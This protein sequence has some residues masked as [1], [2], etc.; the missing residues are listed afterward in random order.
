MNLNTALQIVSA[1]VLANRKLNGRTSQYTTP[2]LWGTA[3]CGKTTG[4]E[5]VADGLGIDCR[6]VILAQYDAGELGGF[7]VLQ[8]GEMHRARPAF[9][10]TEG[11]GILFLDELPQAPVANQNI[12]AQLVNERRIGEHKLGDGW[13]IVC[14]G[15]DLKHRAGT[16]AMPSHLKDRLLHLEVEP[17]LDDTLEY[18]NAKGVDPIVCGFLRFS[19]DQLSV[20]DKDAKAC[21][22][23][24]SW[25]KISNILSWGLPRAAESQAFAGQVG[26][27]AGAK[28]EA[29]LQMYR[30]LPNP[31]QPLTDPMNAPV[32]EKA[33][34]LYALLAGI[35]ARVNDKNAD[36][37]LRYVDR[38]PQGEFG[39]FAVKSAKQRYPEIN[40][41]PAFKAWAVKNHTLLL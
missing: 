18:F 40:K 17:S 39:A 20:F 26:A 21:P 14:A 1:S 4:V 36:N 41:A 9:L 38:I 33:S 35:S 27:G 24:R 25:E 7:P 8:D 5:S 30:E 10:P 16:N 13:S 6:V 32:P 31:E 37:F 11:E 28:F 19:A 23:P 12:A 3:G 15:N 22:S 34:I 2:M 29:F